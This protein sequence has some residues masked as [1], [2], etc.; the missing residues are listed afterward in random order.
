MHTAKIKSKYMV[1]NNVRFTATDVG[2]QTNSRSC[3]RLS[4]QEP[5][6]SS[7]KEQQRQNYIRAFTGYGPRVGRQI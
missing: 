2:G 7:S 4:A 6:D 1:D 5:T 3:F